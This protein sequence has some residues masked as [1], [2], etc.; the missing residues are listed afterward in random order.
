MYHILCSF[1]FWCSKITQLHSFPIDSWLKPHTL[2]NE[3][4]IVTVF[5]QCL[6]VQIEKNIFVRNGGHTPFSKPSHAKEERNGP[7]SANWGLSTAKPRSSMLIA[8]SIPPLPPHPT[9]PAGVEPK[10]Q[11]QCQKWHHKLKM[12]KFQLQS[13]VVKGLNPDVHTRNTVEQH[14]R[15]TIASHSSIIIVATKWAMETYSSIIGA[16]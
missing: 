7:P 11:G 1:G 14:Q 6:P 13:L 8:S 9:L 15:F 12:C 2:I 5:S 4:S 16:L 3:L 10:S